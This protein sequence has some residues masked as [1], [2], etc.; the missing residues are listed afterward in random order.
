MNEP[1]KAIAMRKITSSITVPGHFSNVDAYE[2]YVRIAPIR[3]DEMDH[4]GSLQRAE[5]RGMPYGTVAYMSTVAQ[6]ESGAWLSVLR[7]MLRS[8]VC[9]MFGL[10]L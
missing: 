4:A 1:D 2:I 5:H 6:S 7:Q 10:D 3:Y 9:E 8:I